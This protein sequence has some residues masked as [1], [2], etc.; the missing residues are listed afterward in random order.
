MKLLQSSRSGFVNIVIRGKKL[1]QPLEFMLQSVAKSMQE[2][3]IIE[4]NITVITVM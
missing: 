2:M 3:L 1:K 4:L